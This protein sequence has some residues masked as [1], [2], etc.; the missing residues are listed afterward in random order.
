MSSELMAATS[1]ASDI[2]SNDRPRDAAEIVDIGA[3]KPI[4]RPNRKTVKPAQGGNLLR[5][6]PLSALSG[7]QERLNFSASRRPPQRA[8]VARSVEQVAAPPP[9]TAGPEHLTLALIGAV[10]GDSDAIAV[11]LDR[12]NQRIVRLRQDDAHAGWVL[13]SVVGRAFTLKKADQVETLAVQRRKA[14]AAG[15]SSPKPASAR[16]RRL[17]R[18]VSTRPLRRSVRRTTPKSGE[19]GGL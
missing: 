14:P 10:V 2:L 19:A 1:S 4:A 5:S 16:C 8:V 3:V 13:N 15:A 18:A 7:T 6:V 17:P 9:P 12:T 11:F